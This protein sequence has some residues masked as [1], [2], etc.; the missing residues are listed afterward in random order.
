MRLPYGTRVQVCHGS[1][2]D[3]GTVGTVVHPSKILT[4]GRGIPILPGYYKPVDWSKEVAIEADGGR[5]LTMYKNRLL[6][7]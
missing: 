4:N 5:M 2:L 7:A 6:P 1:G 3:S